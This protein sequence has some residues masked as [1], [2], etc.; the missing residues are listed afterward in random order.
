MR[1]K[2]T[3]SSCI[4]HQTDGQQNCLWNLDLWIWLKN[5]VKLDF[6]VNKRRVPLNLKSKL[7]H[8]SMGYAPL[9]TWKLRCTKKPNGQALHGQVQCLW[10][11]SYLNF[12]AWIFL[13]RNFSLHFW[14]RPAI[15]IIPDATKNPWFWHTFWSSIRSRSWQIQPEETW[16]LFCFKYFEVLFSYMMRVLIFDIQATA[17]K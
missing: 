10:W 6:Q 2:N 15:E 1:P 14:S 5:L 8:E 17:F 11:M 13:L 3:C 12:P 16:C 9:E 7:I 4:C